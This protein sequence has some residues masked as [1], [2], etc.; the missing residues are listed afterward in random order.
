MAKPSARSLLGATTKSG[1][2]WPTR[3]R[4]PT[5]G[6]LSDGVESGALGNGE[7]HP[8][9]PRT[10]WIW[11]PHPRAARVGHG[12]AIRFPHQSRKRICHLDRS[13]V[14]R[15]HS[16]PFTKH[17]ITRHN[18]A[19]YPDRRQYDGSRLFHVE[20]FESGSE[21]SATNGSIRAKGAYA[22]TASTYREFIFSRNSALFLVFDN[23]STSNSIAS[24]G[25]SGFSTLRRTQIRCRSSFGISSSSLRVPER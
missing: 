24:T 18:R 25:E 6:F 23:R 7:S 13:E 11:V 10:L 20:Q 17:L 3:T 8:L 22:R 15:S 14:E 12:E 16:Q 4:A 2:P 9:S 1:A 21:T 5:D 19:T